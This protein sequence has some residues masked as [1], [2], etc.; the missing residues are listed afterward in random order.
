MILEN[1]T[2]K[3][4]WILVKTPTN[5]N[6]KYLEDK[7]GIEKDDLQIIV[8]PFQRPRII[9]KE[10]YI[11]MI[12]HFPYYNRATKEIKTSEIDFIIS[13]D[14]L[15]TVTD[16]N[17]PP[18]LELFDEIENPD[19]KS[20]HNTK[21][22]MGNLL[23][24]ILHNLLF[25]LSPMLNHISQDLDTIENKIKSQTIVKKE[26]IKDIL[27]IKTNIINFRKIT[28]SHKN[29]IKKLIITGGDVFNPQK[30]NPYF[31]ELI[32]YTIEIWSA[33]E[34]Y[35][36]TINALHETYESMVTFKIN[37]IM[38]ILT[39]FSVIVFPLTLLAAI[40]G[41][42]TVNMPLVK[43]QHGFWVI[44]GIMFAGSAVMWGYFKYKKWI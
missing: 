35:T 25:Y 28:Q 12:L 8:P 18:I 30:L 7:F 41:M 4:K 17:L 9:K 38:K 10:N 26:Y 44:I 24:E 33:L 6:L 31:K 27:T 23:Y 2:K 5:S 37:Q 42:N 29:V 15:I 43:N 11:V 16:G 3:I 13:K 40:F 21:D 32:E 39:L 20:K 19:H 14:F 36:Y 22:N 34:N 1:R